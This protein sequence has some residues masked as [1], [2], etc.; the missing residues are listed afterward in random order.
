MRIGAGTRPKVVIGLSCDAPLFTRRLLE[1]ASNCRQ[2]RIRRVRLELA[3]ADLETAR[4]KLA[5]VE[6]RIDSLKETRRR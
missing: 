1:M 2:H 4:L 5:A 6:M 3:G